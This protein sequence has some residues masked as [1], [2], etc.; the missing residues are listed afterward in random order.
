MLLPANTCREKAVITPNG[1]DIRDYFFDGGLGDGDNDSYVSVYGSAPGRGLELLLVC[2]ERVFHKLR[3]ANVPQGKLR[4]YYGFSKSFVEHGEKTRGKEF[5]SRWVDFMK[6]RIE[7]M[8]EM[9]VEYVGMVDHEEL[10]KG[11]AAS[12][13]ILYPTSYPETGCVTLMK[14]MASG[15]LPITSKFATSTL[16]ELTGQWDLG[17]ELEGIW[18]DDI[19]GFSLVQKEEEWPTN[20]TKFIDAYVENIVQ[21][22]LNVESMREKR[23]KMIVY[24]RNR[25]SWT[26]VAKLWKQEFEK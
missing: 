25:F 11:Y 2:W 16:P 24:A 6:R 18:D 23:K 5:F 21:A 26:N 4:I 3:A 10:V 14:A 15:A 8:A 9:G 12:S 22:Y 19:F 13:F 20:L 1:I 7:S 17:V